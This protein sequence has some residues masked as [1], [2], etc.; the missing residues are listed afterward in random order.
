[1]TITSQS[2]SLTLPSLTPKEKGF[3]EFLEL[4]TKRKNYSPSYAEIKDHF[5]FASYNSVQR[6]LK[7]LHNKGYIH[8]P[9][10]N[11]KRALKILHGANSF[12]N[13]PSSPPSLLQT[14][15]ALPTNELLSL[16]LMGFVAAGSPIEAISHDE[17]ID[18]PPSLI[19]SPSKSFAL[20]V[21]GESM[22]NDGIYDEDIILVQ[23]Q[24]D[25]N[26][27]ETVVATIDNEA[28]VKHLYTYSKH[29]SAGFDGPCVELRPANDNMDSMW[30]SPDEV[31]IKGVLVGL[32]RRF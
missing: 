4:Y 28:T 22:I 30:F 29:E 26:N 18:I 13:A 20:K 2:S 21:V 8:N 3:L 14:P 11:Q 32:I 31:Q 6:Y 23:K 15:H 9:G 27:G 17:Y 24:E 5:G 16:P 7:Q 19:R 10:E 25:A 12:K 1:M